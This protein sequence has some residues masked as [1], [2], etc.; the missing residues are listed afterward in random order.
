MENFEYFWVV[1]NNNSSGEEDI[2]CRMNK[3]RKLIKCLNSL[4]LEKNMEI[5][6]KI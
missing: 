6:K 2:N 1:L 3:G 5:W 4:L